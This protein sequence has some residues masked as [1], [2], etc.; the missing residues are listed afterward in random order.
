VYDGSAQRI[1]VDGEDAGSGGN[2]SGV[3]ASGNTAAI[4]FASWNDT[5]GT[6]FVGNMSDVKIWNYPLEEIDVI[7]E[8]LGVVGGYI[9]QWTT[10]MQYDTNDD[11]VIDLV[12]FANWAATWLACDRYPESACP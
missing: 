11:C 7:G 3:D 1:Y 5:D 2:I 9:C 10:D 6:G 12:D 8:Y 4:S